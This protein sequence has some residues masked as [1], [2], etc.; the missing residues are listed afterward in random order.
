MTRYIIGFDP[1]GARRLDET[2]GSSPHFGWA[3]FQVLPESE[4]AFDRTHFALIRTG[5][6]DN[7]ASAYTAVMNDPYLSGDNTI[8]A[9][10][11][12]AP[13]G[14]DSTN[15]R[16]LDR[17]LRHYYSHPVNAHILS[18]NSLRGAVIIQGMMIAREF[19]RQNPAIL[20]TESHPFI[21]MTQL[22]LER[23]QLCDL[24][25]AGHP[26]DSR[27]CDRCCAVASAYSAIV[28]DAAM[29]GHNYAGWYNAHI[30]PSDTDAWSPPAFSPLAHQYWLPDLHRTTRGD[31][32]CRTS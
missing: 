22:G 26:I 23:T 30:G 12:D 25:A 29:H 9:I 14:F 4:S 21:V 5:V 16:E 28:M 8:V 24:S 11:I 7:A 2:H 1:G 19:Y 18:Q 27:N 13:L 32:G 6:A 31:D 15:D 3:I 20:I 17:L 10:G